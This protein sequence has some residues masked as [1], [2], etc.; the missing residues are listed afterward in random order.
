MPIQTVFVHAIFF[1]DQP[2]DIRYGASLSWT[3]YY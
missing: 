1:E 3:E 2:F